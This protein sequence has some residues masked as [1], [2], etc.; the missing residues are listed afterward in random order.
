MPKVTSKGSSGSMNMDYGPNWADVI[1]D[2]K[3]SARDPGKSTGTGAPAKGFGA[4][5]GGLVGKGPSH[6]DEMKGHARK[7]AMLRSRMLEQL[8]KAQKKKDAQYNGPGQ[9]SRRSSKFTYG[10]TP[11]GKTIGYFGDIV[12]SN[13]HKTDLDTGETTMPYAPES[14]AVAGGPAEASPSA[15]PSDTYKGNVA[16]SQGQFSDP[17]MQLQWMKAMGMIPND[18]TNPNLPNREEGIALVPKT[19]PAN[20][21]KGEAVISAPVVKK[22][23]G[24]DYP[25]GTTGTPKKPRDYRE[26][27]LEGAKSYA[28][29]TGDA[30][31]QE[32]IMK[33][34]LDELEGIQSYK[35]GTGDE[36]DQENLMERIL[37]EMMG[38]FFG[39]AVGEG[40][41]VAQEFFQP[42]GKE[43]GETFSPEPSV[44]G[45]PTEDITAPEEAPFT[46]PETNINQLMGDVTGQAP[47]DPGY[48]EITESVGPGG[49]R[50][51][52]GTGD[53]TAAKGPSAQDLQKKQL[54]S[55]SE[56]AKSMYTSAVTLASY[57][58]ERPN[59]PAAQYLNEQSQQRMKASK[60]LQ[61][62]YQQGVQTLQAAEAQEAEQEAQGIA[63]EHDARAR[64]T[65]ATY[66]S[67]DRQ[68]KLDRED[69]GESTK[70]IASLAK[71][72]A[73]LEGGDAAK[74]EEILN[75]L[76]MYYMQQGGGF[77]EGG[78]TAGGE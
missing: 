52:S 9:G 18:A 38:P 26:I 15:G 69:R 29:G 40:T 33:G 31:A 34:V 70:Q 53:P 48:D 4:L 11:G 68:R 45:P 44:G 1:F 60:Q 22:V 23:M 5:G 37:E 71:S 28:S 66:E 74:T 39:G 30:K 35:D 41:S 72:L 76:I 42:T 64:E 24:G 2:R 27:I 25:N 10:D 14:G 20:L 21:H 6:I 51:F 61:M 49:E 67:E 8:I 17:V 62:M 46:G 47:P 32:G 54:E 43:Q 57:A 63:A 78:A 55:L 19:G 13:L 7:N 77:Q 36:D 16:K 50:K 75:Q 56:Q 59:S 58:N 3:G 12:Q 73:G 65:Q